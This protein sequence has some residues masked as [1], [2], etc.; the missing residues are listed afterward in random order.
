MAVITVRFVDENG[1]RVRSTITVEGNCTQH[2]HD[3]LAYDAV[4]E[5]INARAVLEEN[6]DRPS[7]PIERGIV[8][9][10]FGI[11]AIA[12]WADNQFKFVPPL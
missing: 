11:T 8:S 10:E 6:P 1:D 7:P 3:E 2:T 9:D 4:R 12:E 5:L